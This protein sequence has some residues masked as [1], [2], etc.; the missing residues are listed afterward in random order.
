[1]GLVRGL[2]R[3]LLALAVAALLAVGALALA[4]RPPS[5]PVPPR[6]ATLAGVTLVQPGSGAVPD[7]TLRVEGGHIAA[8]APAGPEAEGAPFAGAY[9]LPGLVDLHVHHPPALA[10]G[11]RELFA[12]LFLRHGVTTVRDVGGAW[13]G[14]LRRHAARIREGAFP[15]PRM[16]M[17][18][19]FLD[20]DPPVWPTAR[21]L[22]DAEEAREAVQDLRREG[23]D[24]AKL[25]NG[26]TPPVVVALQEA[27]AEAGLPLVAHVPWTVRLE[28]MR[29]AE[30]QHGMGLTEERIDPTAREIAAYVRTSRQRRL[31][32][33]PTL[34]AFAR[35]AR[36]GDPTA[37]IS[38]AARLLPRYHRNTLWSPARNPLA[39]FQH[40]KAEE[41]VRAL[42][43][44]VAALHRGG[45]P[46]LAG[47][48]TLNPGVAP[49][50]SLHEELR[51]LADAGLGATGAWQ[52][53]TTGAGEALGIPGL[54]RLRV[55][56]PADL[57]VFRRDPSRDLDALDSLV[58]V[59]A[60]GRLYRS[61]ELE[62][63]ATRLAAPLR[64]APYE[65][66]ASAAASALVSWLGRGL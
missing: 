1:M 45:V 33:T 65:P 7:R 13:P 22:H 41:R 27:A 3:G 36:L 56:A 57:L 61:E 24:C 28:E 40:R 50:A 19:P 52:T 2:R 54:G 20:G 53:A 15:G 21:V 14:S 26:L 34:V 59:V 25:Y 35:A 18:G 9:V 39:R 63:A 55:G 51:L 46:V 64:R 30:V 4:L 48:D 17:C 12:A 58:A 16:R 62:A 10:V 66:L 32:H 38:P 43:R 29:D 47:T 42:S 37:R 5:V 31:R 6:G 8:I 49:G 11:E 44:L 23:F 60:D